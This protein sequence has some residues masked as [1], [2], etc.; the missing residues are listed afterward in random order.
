MFIVLF[1]RHRNG[2]G[3]TQESA[4]RRAPGFTATAMLASPHGG[5]N[6]AVFNEVEL[7]ALRSADIF[8]IGSSNCSSG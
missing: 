7:L 2:I 5:R 6:D 4:W 1:F 3:P 8:F